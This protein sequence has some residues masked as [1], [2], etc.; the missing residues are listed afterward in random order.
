M[1]IIEKLICCVFFSVKLGSVNSQTLPVN[2]KPILDYPMRDVSICLGPDST[3]YMTGTTGDPDMW[4]VTADIKIFKSTDLKKWLPVVTKPRKRA[5]VWN[6]D[7]EG[8]WEKSIPMRDGAPFRP[9]WAPEIH[10]FN[11]HFFL[12]YCLPNHGSGILKSTTGKAEG[13][14]IKAL[15]IDAPINQ[16]I[17]PALF[18][19]DDGKVY[20]VSGE[21]NITPLKNDL[22]ATAGPAVLAVPTNAKHVGF[23]GCF[24]FKRDGKY[25][26]SGAEFIDGN[27]QCFVASANYIYGPYSNRYLVIPH[28]GHNSFFKDLEGNW[29]ASFFGNDSNA[30]FRDRPA[31][32]KIIFDDNGIVKMAEEPKLLKELS[33]P[34]IFKGNDSTAYRDPAVIYEANQF[35]LFFTLT[36]IESDGKVYMYLASS[37]SNDL[38]NWSAINILTPRNQALDYSS[39]GNII[40]FNNEWIICLQ[41]YPR[42]NYTSNQMPK[43]GSENARLYI[44]RS[45]DLRNWSSPE[46]LQVK[47]PTIGFSEMG[48]M[49]DPYLFEDKD[50]KGKWWCF[51]KQ[52]GVSRSYSYDLKTWTYAGHAPAGENVCVLVK[53]NQYFLMHSP[54]NGIGIKTSNN[55]IDWKDWG[56][57]IT[58][59]QQN[60]NWAKGRITAGALLDLNAN[61]SFKNYLLFFHGSGPLSEKQGDFDK[62]A[63]IG[64]A[65][66]NNLIDWNWPANK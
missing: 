14:Y 58:L 53:N 3:Y 43:Y 38:K 19:D 13:P 31:L 25:Y 5:T 11:H 21:G 23:E 55:L 39:P 62:N 4:G 6:V 2:L 49:I 59:D 27:Y 66:S 32:I 50:E 52:N 34:I 56:G 1:R 61:K 46:L 30:P 45:K 48:R 51:Y 10:Y 15:K 54:E 22:S 57:L 64:I 28:G 29:W 9:L 26:M 20:L 8:T 17:D 37:V 36:K 65:W 12:T 60:W 47:G 40:R 24:L 44:M 42:P 35:H 33:S 41:T 7:R 63:S 18:R 16:D